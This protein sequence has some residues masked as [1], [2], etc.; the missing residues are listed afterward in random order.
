[1]PEERAMAEVVRFFWSGGDAG[2]PLTKIPEQDRQPLRVHRNVVQACAPAV[3]KQLEE[4]RFVA[5]AWESG[6]QI[7][8]ILCH[9]NLA[10]GPADNLLVDTTAL[11][12]V[13]LRVG[14][15][16][17]LSEPT[18]LFLKAFGS[19]AAT[20]EECM[21]ARRALVDWL[22]AHGQADMAATVKHFS[23]FPFGVR[24][25]ALEVINIWRHVLVKG[26]QAEQIDRFLEE[27]GKRFE[28][29]GWSRDTIIE[30][31]MNRDEHQRNR[32]YC[33][34]SGAGPRP[35][36]LLCLNRSTDR[37][38]R[39]GTYSLLDDR[40]GLGLPEVANTIQHVLAEVLEPAAATVGLEVTYPRL[41]PISRVGA[42]TAAAMTAF[43]EAAD[44]QWPLSVALEP[45]W[46]HFVVTA[47]REGVAFKPEEVTA[48]FNASGWE[49]GPAIE[50]AKRFYAEAV[51]LEEYEEEEGRQPA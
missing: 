30:G 50:L 11:P 46:R 35:R 9:P 7:C 38:V 23:S 36:V 13:V 42:R 10:K 22:T 16:D 37:R 49:E 4:G 34:I 44:G 1:M 18:R 20:A 45:A 6:G 27:V 40:P 14:G 8:L 12:R 32:F 21:A 48:W 43:A 3:V 47:F 41:G 17:E 33:W 51:L 15:W 28:A 39:G 29:L 19:D 2:V 24:S 5:A 31:Q 26:R 25:D